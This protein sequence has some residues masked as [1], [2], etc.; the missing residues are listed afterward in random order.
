MHSYLT[1]FAYKNT[2]TED[3]WAALESASG[4]PVGKVMSSWTKQMGYPV[5]QV[6][7]MTTTIM[8]D[9]D[10]FNCLVVEI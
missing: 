2:F 8:K 6:L 4:K 3:L 5:I 7:M 9:D 10:D 1:K